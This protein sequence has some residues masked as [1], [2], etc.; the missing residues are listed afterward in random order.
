MVIGTLIVS[1]S[2]H[3]NKTHDAGVDREGRLLLDPLFSSGTNSKINYAYQNLGMIECKG[4]D[5]LTGGH[6]FKYIL[7]PNADFGGGCGSKLNIT[8]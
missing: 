7:G 6:L 5:G 8:K 2:A 3:C 1:G 4:A